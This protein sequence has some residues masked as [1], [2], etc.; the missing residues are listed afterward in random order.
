MF[1]DALIGEEVACGPG[2]VPDP[3]CGLHSSPALMN[4]GL[5]ENMNA[6]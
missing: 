1:V 5:E 3:Q 2:I 4:E 6:N